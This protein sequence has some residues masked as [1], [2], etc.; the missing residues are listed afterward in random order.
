MGNVKCRTL[1]ILV[2]FDFLTCTLCYTH[3]GDASTQHSE[4]IQMKHVLTGTIV[5]ETISA[6]CIYT[7]LGSIVSRNS[8]DGD[9]IS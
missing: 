7:V 4:P 8:M 2:V 6:W 1:Y 3:N 9:L 5:Q